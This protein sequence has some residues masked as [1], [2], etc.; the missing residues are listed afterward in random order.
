M[1]LGV[2]SCNITSHV[3]GLPLVIQCL[4]HLDLQVL[5]P[6]HSSGSCTLPQLGLVLFPSTPLLVFG[7]CLSIVLYKPGLCSASTSVR[8]SR[9]VISSCLLIT[10]SLSLYPCPSKLH[11]SSWSP[12]LIFSS[13]PPKSTSDLEPQIELYSLSSSGCRPPLSTSS[14]STWLVPEHAEYWP[15]LSSLNPQSSL[16]LTWCRLVGTL[17]LHSPLIGSKWLCKLGTPRLATWV[18]HTSWSQSPAMTKPCSWS[19]RS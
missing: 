11:L 14:E 9:H 5:P 6:I 18:Q 10:T 13:V 2:L 15:S 4:H 12:H 1:M 3:L 19:S 17:V 7:H 16:R 8:I